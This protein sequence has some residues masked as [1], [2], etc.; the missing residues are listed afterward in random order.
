MPQARLE[1]ALLISGVPYTK[2]AAVLMPEFI[3][4]SERKSTR[5]RMEC[6]HSLPNL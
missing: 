4:V 2:N 5:I 3:H 6:A 1:L